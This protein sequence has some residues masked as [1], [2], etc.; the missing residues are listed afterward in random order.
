MHVLLNTYVTNLANG[1]L[2]A[3]GRVKCLHRCTWVEPLNEGVTFY[4]L[5]TYKVEGL[6]NEF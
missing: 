4:L 2:T 1:F 3:V 6:S 5:S